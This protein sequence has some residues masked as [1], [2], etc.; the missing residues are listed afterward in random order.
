[1]RDAAEHA[2]GGVVLDAGAGHQRYRPF[3]DDAIY[4]AQEHPIAGRQ[5]K[6]IAEYDILSDVKRIPLQEGCVDLVLSTSSL[7]HM[8][9]PERFFT[10]SFRV[11]RPG[12]ALYVNVPFAYLEHEP[13]FLRYGYELVGLFY[14]ARHRLLD[15]HAYPGVKKVPGNPVVE[16]R[17]HGYGYGLGLIQEVL[18]VQ[19]IIGFIFSSRLFGPLLIAVADPDQGCVLKLGID[20]GVEGP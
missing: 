1:M 16:V 17:G 3:F 8:E 15:E 11:L 4:V 12:G 19:V 2:K 6:K 14:G 10:E 20:P 18:I 7:E 5:H 9:F 13:F